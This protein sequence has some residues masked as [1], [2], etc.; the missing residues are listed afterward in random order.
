MKNILFMLH[1][2]V[3]CLC[4]ANA[5][6]TKTQPT[7]QSATVIKVQ[8]EDSHSPYIGGNP[9]DTHCNRPLTRTMCGCH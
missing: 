2:T 8:E 4:T 1:G 7:N 3:R 6:N 5:A 9:S